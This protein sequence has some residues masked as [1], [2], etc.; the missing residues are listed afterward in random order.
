MYQR[1]MVIGCCGA[2]KSTLAKRIQQKTGLPLIHLDKEYWK[3]NWEATKKDI[4]KEKVY[5]LTQEEKWIIDGNY[6]SSMEMRMQRADLIIFMDINKYQCLY[7]AI[8]RT[9]NWKKKHRS[10]MADGCHERI[11]LDFYKF[12]WDFDKNT[13]PRIIELLDD[14]KHIDTIRIRSKKDIEKLWSYL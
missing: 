11:D 9:L 3:P 12:I 8:K 2:G 1:I 4:W 5:S 14:Y 10:D 13:R 6:I 7:Q